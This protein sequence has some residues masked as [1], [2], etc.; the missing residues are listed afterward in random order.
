MLYKTK[1]RPQQLEALRLSDGKPAFAYF[2]TMR[3][4]KTKVTF[5]DAARA[6]RA[7]EIDC[8]LVLAPNGVQRQWVEQAAE[9]CAVEYKAAFYSGGLGVKG[10]RAFKELVSADVGNALKILTLNLE[11]IVN[12][13]GRKLIDEALRNNK[14]MMVV[15][16]STRIKT[17]N[18]ATTKAVVEAGREAVYRRLLN[19][20]PITQSP[21]DLY[22]QFLFLNPAILGKTTYTAFRNRYAVVK[23]SLKRSGLHKF[24]SYCFNQ[25]IDPKTVKLEAL[26][27]RQLMKAGIKPGRDLYDNVV[28]YRN[29]EELEAAIAPYTYRLSRDEVEGL[30]PIVPYIRD[31]EMLPDQRRIYKELEDN[32][33]AHLGIAPTDLLAFFMDENKVE[34]SNGLTMLLKAQQVLGGHVKNSEGQLQYIKHNRINILHSILDEVVGKVIIWA[35]FQPEI[36]EIVTS[37]KSKYGQDAVAEFHGGISQGARPVEKARFQHNPETLFLVGQVHAG[38]VGQTFDAADTIVNYSNDYSLYARLQSIERATAYGKGGIALI[39]MVCP[40]TVDEKILKALKVKEQRAD[41]FHYN[42]TEENGDGN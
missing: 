33:C 36:Q 32:A 3:T 25:G 6:F 9:H 37:L 34:A 39:D 20:T 17:Y 16:E 1:P 7:G 27:Y 23:R 19:G 2:M 35:R 41:S 30:P 15:D 4:G 18:A 38:G 11:S 29:M 14:C 24:R 12:A 40:G 10:K 5:D 13:T 8:L 28:D 42:T 26:T 21:L 31:V 22:S